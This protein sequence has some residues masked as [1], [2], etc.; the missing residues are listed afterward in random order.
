MGREA[1]RNGA[2]RTG[3]WIGA[4]LFALVL[5]LPPP[6][7]FTLPAWRAAALAVLMAIWWATE[8][9]PIAATSM[10]PLA[11]G[12]LLGV[13]DV[14]TAGHAYGSSTIF[15]ILGG[16]FLALALERWN[17]HRRIAYMIMNLV[18]SSARRLVLGV[19]AATAFVSMWVSNTSTTLMMLPVAGSIAALVVPDHE[20]ASPDRRRFSTA[21][22][23][24]VA[25][26]ATIGGLGT[27]I[28]SPT[29]A[30]AVA[31][32]RENVGLAI[33]F[34]D[35]LWFGLPS[36]LLLL[37]LAWWLL[38]RVTHRFDLPDIAAARELIRAEHAALGRWSAPERRVAWIGLSAAAAWI[39]S[40]WLRALPALSALS[41]MGIAMLAALALYLVP[42]GGGHAGRLLAGADF[43]RVPWD[44]LFL[45]GGG[46]ALAAVIDGSGL[47][48]N[49]GAFL[50]QLA[51]L[52]AVALTAVVVLVIVFWTEL[53]SNVAT[54]AT[55]MPVLA[56]M[57]SA[58]G[59]PVLQLVVPAAVAA[60][61]GFMLPVGT[62]PN[63]IVYGSGRVGLRDMMRA[64][65]P[66]DIL[67]AAIV[68]LVATVVVPRLGLR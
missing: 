39:A 66:L 8:A 49:I 47:S 12:P 2:Q 57:A 4:A 52:P 30:L 41:D 42:A 17:L 40:P 51:G 36:V 33:G 43:R 10:L 6:E 61:C 32:L 13:A 14:E 5:W 19:M 28:G 29:N 54:A 22:V 16:C 3:L 63:A 50:S 48:R 46:L 11:A 9:L 62:A 25:Y 38:V 59:V 15:L 24:G 35:W 23:V 7:G 34:A 56:A 53:C 31:Y 20:H 26:A 68:V 60:S 37:P 67:A 18:G 64:G 44:M 21:I 55:F 65:L 45:F 58:T 1:G 27:L